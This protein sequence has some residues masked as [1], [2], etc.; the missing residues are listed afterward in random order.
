VP[1]HKTPSETLVVLAVAVAVASPEVQAEHPA[2]ETRVAKA[3]LEHLIQTL[4][5]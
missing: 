5:G 4:F 2:K 1:E 3:Q